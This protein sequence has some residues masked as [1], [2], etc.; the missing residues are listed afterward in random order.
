MVVVSWKSN[1]Q[2]F[3]QSSNKHPIDQEENKNFVKI[4]EIFQNF[5][6]I[7][8]EKI[9]HQKQEKCFYQRTSVNAY[10]SVFG[11]KVK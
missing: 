1:K 10:Y 2:N 9:N 5:C 11:H 4:E 6:E 8:I 7:Y 3:N